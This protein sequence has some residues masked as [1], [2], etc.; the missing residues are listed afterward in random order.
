MPLEPI[1]VLTLLLALAAILTL[2]VAVLGLWR[3]LRVRRQRTVAHTEPRSQTAGSTAALQ[4]T[5]PLEPPPPTEPPPSEPNRTAASTDLATT[6]VTAARSVADPDAPA[7]GP[8][9]ALMT[10]TKADGSTRVRSL[11]IYSRNESGCVFGAHNCRME[12]ERIV[13]S[14]Q[15]RGIRRVELPGPGGSFAQAS[16][17]ARGRVGPLPGLIQSPTVQQSHLQPNQLPLPSRKR[18]LSQE[19]LG[20]WHGRRSG[21]W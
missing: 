8:V 1:R 7:P 9:A 2:L 16:D 5:R 18:A 10:Y 17:R 11:V 3:R 21:G 19:P 13:K 20:A 12:G 14:F 15:L 4:A 6:P